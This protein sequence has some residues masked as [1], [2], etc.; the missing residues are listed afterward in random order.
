MDI[1]LVHTLQSCIDDC[2][3][4]INEAELDKERYNQCLSGEILKTYINASN[5]A[6]RK[7]KKIRQQLYALQ[8]EQKLEM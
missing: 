4:L 8:E 1:N 3:R 6:I 5:T 2:N 7:I